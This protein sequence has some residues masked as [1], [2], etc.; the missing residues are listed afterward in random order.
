MPNRKKPPSIVLVA[1]HLA[2]VVGE[3]TTFTM[4]QVREA[5]PGVS[6]ID[7]RMRELRQLDWVIDTYRTDPT[8]Q[9]SEL[10]VTTI[11]ERVWEPGARRRPDKG[12]SASARSQVY[13]RDD[14]R[15]TVCGIEKGEEYAEP[16]LRG[17]KARLTIG[18]YLPKARGGDPSDVANMRTE[19]ALCNEAV[20]DLTPTIEDFEMI[21]TELANMKNAEKEEIAR[22]QLAGERDRSRTELLNSRINRLPAARRDEIRRLLARYIAKS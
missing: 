22:W 4:E 20:R 21:K 7:R 3:G 6:Q 15:C 8:L 9:P 1:E 19:C 17:K 12:V 10:R 16:S 11:G 2:H 18:H 13:R 14:Y 5:I